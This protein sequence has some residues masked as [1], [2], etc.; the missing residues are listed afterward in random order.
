MTVQETGAAIWDHLA[1]N[2]IKTVLSGGACVTIY[3]QNKY[4]SRD[5]DFV[6]ADYSL[7][8]LDPLMEELGFGR[9]R[10]N[11][12]YENPDCPYFVEFPPSPLM[13]GEEFVNKTAL[14]K[15][16]YGRLRL[17]RPVDSVKDRLAAFYHWND[18][19]SLE[20]ALMICKTKRINMKEV[21]RWS[22]KEG[23]TEKFLFFK[24]QLL[25]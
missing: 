15:N 20:Q 24:E 5:L 2:S 11:R 9:T 12:H 18:R 16:K 8:E 21:E 1:K 6:M 3:S 22:K 25:A 19:Q 14:I 4:Q 17:L 10:N 7:K 13:V 23:M